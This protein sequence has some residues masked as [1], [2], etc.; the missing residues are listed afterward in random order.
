MKEHF[1]LILFKQLRLTHLL[2]F[3]TWGKTLQGILNLACQQLRHCLSSS[4]YFFILF[5]VSCTST[6]LFCMCVRAFKCTYVCIC[7]HYL[8]RPEVDI[9]LPG[10]LKKCL[11]WNS[12]VTD[13]LNQV[14]KLLQVAT[15]S[16]ATGSNWRWA[17]MPC[18]HLHG[19]YVAEFWTPLFHYQCFTYWNISIA[20]PWAFY[21]LQH[22][23]IF[24]FNLCQLISE[25]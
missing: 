2:R 11:W 10:I 19:F 22:R 5:C 12:G 13:S 24:F 1:S 14:V 15:S 16:S 20:P 17:T 9:D 21:I 6:Y 3:R 23:Y 4:F 8:C 7:V 18:N 25:V